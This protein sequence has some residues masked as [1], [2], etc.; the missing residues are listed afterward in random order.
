MNKLP[1]PPEMIVCYRCFKRVAHWE[2]Y[3]PHCME[4]V[5]Q[6]TPFLP[7]KGIRFHVNVIYKIW[8]IAW[9]DRDSPWTSRV[10]CA[11]LIIHTMPFLLVLFAPFII[12]RRLT[13]GR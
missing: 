2:N 3:C 1:P 13:H 9:F 11:L 10:C 6:H 12:W 5:G 7:F 8:D 4:G